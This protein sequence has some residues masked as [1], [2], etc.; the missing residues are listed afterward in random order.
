MLRMSLGRLT[1]AED[2]FGKADLCL[3][4]YL[5]LRWVWRRP[6]SAI[7]QGLFPHVAEL[8]TYVIA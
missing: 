1:Y 5:G 4:V 2:E 3:K 8:A 7:T 6:V